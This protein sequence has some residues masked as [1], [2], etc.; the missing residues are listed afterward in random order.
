M[1]DIFLHRLVF[2]RVC[3][4][5]VAEV[6]SVPDPREVGREVDRDILIFGLDFSALDPM[7]GVAKICRERQ[8]RRRVQ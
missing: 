5:K 6:Y 2:A 3:L 1:S 8:V 7:V 4:G